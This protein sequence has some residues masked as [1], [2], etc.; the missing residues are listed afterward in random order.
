MVNKQRLSITTCSYLYI[1][2]FHG[3]TVGKIH[4][5][6]VSR[7]GNAYSS[8]TITLTCLKI[9]ITWLLRF[10]NLAPLLFRSTD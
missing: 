6:Y 8:T 9:A 3:F 1:K 5:E 10:T 7:K 4:D 2:E